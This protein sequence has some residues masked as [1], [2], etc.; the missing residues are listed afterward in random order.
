[1]LY[2][3]NVT[4]IYKSNNIIQHVD[5]KP[6]YA[7]FDKERA[8]KELRKKEKEVYDQFLKIVEDKELVMGASF[9]G[10]DEKSFCLYIDVPGEN[11]TLWCN[12]IIQECPFGSKEDKICQS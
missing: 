4:D 6:I 12:G 5:T 11:R 8:E 9:N 10:Y 3:V 1:M 7:S 2:V